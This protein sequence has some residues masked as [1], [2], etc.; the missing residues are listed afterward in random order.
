MRKNYT[1]G[2][3]SLVD[4]NLQDGQDVY[5]DAG[6]SV[7]VVDDEESGSSNFS[8]GLAVGLTVGVVLTL[9]LILA[10]SVIIL[11]VM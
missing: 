6:F 4:V 7:A 9:G 5:S 3:L 10:F 8:I 2:I 1:R 11:L